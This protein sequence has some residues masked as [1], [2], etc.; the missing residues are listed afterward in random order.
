MCWADEEN[1]WVSQSA[2]E[3]RPRHFE[4]K[5]SIDD[6][7][8]FVIADLCMQKVIS[9]GWKKL[10]SK[11]TT[12][13]R[14]VGMLWTG[15]AKK[16]ESKWVKSHL[17]KKNSHSGLNRNVFQLNAAGVG[18][19]GIYRGKQCVPT[20]GIWCVLRKSNA[21]G[22]I[23]D[24]SITYYTH[25]ARITMQVVRCTRGQTVAGPHRV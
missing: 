6:F 23:R 2:A 15:I 4:V 11:Y 5:V 10:T 20:F 12:L 18:P 3:C 25:Y 14:S 22:V 8:G 21:V 1:C 9:T 13:G 24:I 17:N 19:V 16:N 7:T